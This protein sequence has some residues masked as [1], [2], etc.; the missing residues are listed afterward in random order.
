M[1]IAAKE[2]YIQRATNVK[3]SFTA[4]TQQTIYTAPTGDDFTFAIIEGI[5]ACDHG[6]QQT[7]LDISITDT[8]SNEFFLFKEKNISAHETI[9]LIVN[10]GL[11]LR[12]GEIIK[13]QVNHANIDLVFSVIEYAKGD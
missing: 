1:N 8:S 5:F 4:T 10:S 7:N 9:E 11:I 2:Q 3:Y 12:Q 6:N 13:A